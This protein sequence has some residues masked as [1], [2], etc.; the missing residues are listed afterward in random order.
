[1]LARGTWPDARSQVGRL[2]QLAVLAASAGEGP[3]LLVIGD[4][5]RH[6]LPWR[7]EFE[8]PVAKAGAAA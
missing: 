4:V 6:S 1:V 2:D 8:T 3:A 7:A 5:V